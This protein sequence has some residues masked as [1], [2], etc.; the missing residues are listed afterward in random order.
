MSDCKP[1]QRRTELFLVIGSPLVKQN[2]VLVAVCTLSRE[3]LVHQLGLSI[4]R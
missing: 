2:M 4:S 1:S 3:S